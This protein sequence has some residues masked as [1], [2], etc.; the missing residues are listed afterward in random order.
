MVVVGD[1]LEFL[2][3]AGNTGT[4]QFHRQIARGNPD[5]ECQTDSGGTNRRQQ[6][7]RDGVRKDT[8][9]FFFSTQC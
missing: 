4:D 2:R 9:R 5:V 8:P 6:G 7:V 1:R 3:N